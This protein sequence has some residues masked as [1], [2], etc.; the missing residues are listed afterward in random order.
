MSTPLVINIEKYGDFDI[1]YSV[2]IMQAP[3]GMTKGQLASTVKM[4]ESTFSTSEDV[5]AV[6]KFLKGLGFESVKL[7]S[8]RIGGDL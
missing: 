7:Q 6:K 1:P 2:L 8:A 5:A 3:Y 4:V